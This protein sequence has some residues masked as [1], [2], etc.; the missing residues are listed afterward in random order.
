MVLFVCLMRINRIIIIYM[1]N[2]VIVCYQGLEAIEFYK[3]NDTISAAAAE[4]NMHY[5]YTN[6]RRLNN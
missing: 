6:I 4:C 3:F 2:I 5:L 1:N